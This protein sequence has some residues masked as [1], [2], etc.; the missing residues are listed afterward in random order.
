MLKN[1]REFP[2]KRLMAGA[3]AATC[4]SMSALSFAG[5]KPLN[6]DIEGNYANVT[7]IE[8]AEKA[9]VQIIVPESI[10]KKT[11]LK[12]VKGDYDLVEALNAMLLGSNLKYSFTSD[13]TILVTESEEGSEEKAEKKDQKV[14]EVVVTGSRIRNVAPTSPVIVITREDI[15]RQGLSTAED[16]VRSLPQNFSSVNMATTLSEAGR[17]RDTPYGAEGHS[18]ANLRGLGSNATLILINGRRTASAASYEDGR[19]NLGNIPVGAI[20]RVEVLLD[21]ASAIYGADALGGVINFILQKEYSGSKTTVRYETSANAARHYSI[22]QHLGFGWDSGNALVSLGFQER[23]STSAYKAGYDSYDFTDRGGRNYLSSNLYWAYN[24]RGNVRGADGTHY[25]SLPVGHDGVD[26][27]IDDLSIDNVEKYD[28]A[29]YSPA[30]SV[31][32]ETTSFNFNVEQ[33][34]GLGVSLFMDGGYSESATAATQGASAMYLRVPTTN[35][36]NNTGEDLVVLYLNQNEISSGLIDYSSYR[37]TYKTYNLTTGLKVDLWGDWQASGEVAASRSTADIG[38]SGTLIP[39]EAIAGVDEEGNRI[40][41]FNP[42]GDQLAHEDGFDFSQYAFN[43]TYRSSGNDMLRGTVHA[44][45]SVMQIAG[46][47][48]K[49]AVGATYRPEELDL[50]DDQTRQNVYKANMTTWKQEVYGYFFESSIPLISSENSKS[51][52]DSLLLT[53]AGRYDEYEYSGYFDSETEKTD[54]SY[55]RFSP[56]FGVL[57]EPTDT[58]KV[59][60]SWSESFRAPDLRTLFEGETDWRTE[61]EVLDPRTGEYVLVPFFR[62]GNPNIK[63]ETSVTLSG[64]I[65]WSPSFVPGLTVSSTYTKIDWTDKIGLGRP[66]YPYIRNNVDA[67]PDVFIRDENGVLVKVKQVNVNLA[68]RLV[69]NVD[70]SARYEMDTDYGYFIAEL[71]GTVN[72]T[73]EE[74]AFENTP[75]TERIETDLGPDK[76][77]YNVRFGWD[78]GSYGANLYYRYSS[79]YSN[80]NRTGGQWVYDGSWVFTPNPPEAVEHWSTWDLTGYWDMGKG[81]RINAG[82]RNLLNNKFPFFDAGRGYDGSR[83][84]TRGRVMYMDVTKEFNF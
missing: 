27:T 6:L 16:I 43:T 60:A 58:V 36:F 62:G 45:G 37:N 65:E 26:W 15:D 31:S 10:A 5:D 14:E 79:G 49:L 83:V 69:E 12:G 73:D 54:K 38:S 2:R 67:F 78:K 19:V 35:P 22:D 40:P 21:G 56:K 24:T 4:I 11:W 75:V 9:G 46:G 44:D 59:R 61:E 13:D 72:L 70:I 17:D 23:S 32:S 64:G 82:V 51:W 29:K 66:W 50:S 52:A 39:E 55:S 18:F 76:V 63:P 77:N 25:G 84:D 81:V 33:D 3:V 20:E 34:L 42:F 80:V 53:V 68:L 41:A 71:A 48:I 8:L 28:R 1:R 74:Q 30:G 7:L 47:D 57:W